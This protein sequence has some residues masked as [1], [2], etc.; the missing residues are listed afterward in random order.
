MLLGLQVCT[1]MP[2]SPQCVPLVPVIPQCHPELLYYCIKITSKLVVFI[3]AHSYSPSVLV[4]QE[5]RHSVAKIL[6]RA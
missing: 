3:S 6:L 2:G 5:V 1:I 4:P